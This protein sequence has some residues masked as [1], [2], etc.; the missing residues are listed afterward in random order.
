MGG[1]FG[2]VVKAAG[3]HIGDPGSILGRDDLKRREPSHNADL[4]L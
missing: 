1:Q 4:T 2:L 3:W